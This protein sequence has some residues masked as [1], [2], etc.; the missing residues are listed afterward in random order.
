MTVQETSASSPDRL[1][2]GSV[3]DMKRSF[4]YVEFLCSFVLVDYC[5]RARDSYFT[6]AYTTGSD[7]VG[8]D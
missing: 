8:D 7:I 1:R 2:P 3:V 5:A 4:L 6:A